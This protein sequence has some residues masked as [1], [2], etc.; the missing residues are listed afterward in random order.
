M[1]LTKLTFRPCSA[2]W[3]PGR[4]RIEG[5]GGS[6]VVPRGFDRSRESPDQSRNIAASAR[7]DDAVTAKA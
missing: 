2:R 5:I 7:A 4:F 3:I 1:D 6:I